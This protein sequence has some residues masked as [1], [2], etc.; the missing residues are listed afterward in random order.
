MQ[1]IKDINYDIELFT[2]E[3]N[4]LQSVLDEKETTYL[5]YLDQ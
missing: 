4:K 5:E 3:L 1:K 2:K